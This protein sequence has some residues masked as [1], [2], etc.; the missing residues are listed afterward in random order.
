MLMSIKSANFSDMKDREQAISRVTIW[1]AVANVALAGVKLVAGIVGHSA[2]MM[3]DAVHSLSDLVSDVIVLAMIKVSSKGEDESHDYGHGKY[4]TLATA[5][6][7]LLLLVVGAKLMSEGI[8][9]IRDAVAGNGLAVPGAV[10]LWAAI[11]SIAVKEMLFQLTARVG[12]KHNSPAVVTNA[13]HHRT[14]ALSSIGSALGIGAAMLL[15]GKWVILDPLVCCGISV[16]IFCIAVKMAI[17]ALHEL[18]EGSLPQDTENEII[19]IILSVNGIDDVHELKTR[20]N[21]PSII[22]AAHIVV[23]GNTSVSAAHSMATSAESRI[24]EHFGPETQISLHIEP[25]V[26]AE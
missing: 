8:A 2:A 15:G 19:S 24:R 5:A 22:I 16:F 3:A 21:G 6:V 7:A 12:R 17:P 23:D 10:A 1:G 13:W 11:I 26:E 9:K 25:D 20:K 14:D 18:T 4:E